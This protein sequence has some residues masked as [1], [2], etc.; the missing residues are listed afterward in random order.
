MPASTE[1]PPRSAWSLLKT[2][3]FSRLWRA[4]LVSSTGDWISILA[5]LSLAEELAGGSGIV[6]ALT[7]R[8]LPGL[9][10]A[11][12][13]GII[14]DRF[15]RKF[16]M[17]F[18]EVGRAG[19][20]LSLAFASSITHLILVNLLIEALTLLFQPA[21]E[22]TVPRLVQRNEL[23]QA[24]SLSLS[25]A[26]GT[27]PI[28]AL[29]FLAIAPWGD[30]V[31]LGGLLPGTHQ[32]LA[33]LCDAVTYLVS[34]A[35]LTTLPSLPSAKRRR[36]KDGR[37]RWHPMAAVIDFK[38]GVAFVAKHKRVRSVVLAMTV[39]LAGGG[40]VV[41]LG[42]PFSRDVLL[43]GA[44]GFP[45]LLTAF[46]LGAALGIVTVTIFATRF[47]F[48]DILFAFALVL[49]GS[50][51]AAAAFVASLYGAVG[52]I[53]AM[54]F[55]AGA[56]YVLGFAH[57]HE[58]AEDEVRGRAFAALFSLMRIGLLTSM[59]LAL[60]L[61]ELFQG[62]LPG[63]LA[64]GRRMVLFVGGLTM[65]S[66]GVVTLWRVRANL[67]ALGKIGGD[68]PTVT[69]ATTAHRTHQHAVSGVDL[70]DSFDSGDDA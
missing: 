17:L 10:F 70:P 14:A 69:A 50:S 48:K 40:I 9:F 25:A 34:F 42:K 21:K 47:Q 35:I 22:A 13:G 52:W 60:P 30:N 56:A 59:M 46:G 62:W 23:V 44:V 4:G 12:I 58:Q 36:P 16:V 65:L 39:A 37:G 3:P 49:A 55:G 31:T 2:G 8:I 26:Y 51:L 28:G 24:N 1:A 5:T 61:A 29:I 38:E 32:S 64:D 6:L 41:V 54:G 45:A 15:N 27:F 63:L 19:L 20:V 53:G 7:S 68:R 11:A 33:F 57:L 66:S 67:I 43:T 18:T